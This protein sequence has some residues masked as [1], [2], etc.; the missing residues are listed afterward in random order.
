VRQNKKKA[1]MRASPDYVRLENQEYVLYPPLF[2]LSLFISIF[3]FREV[4]I[5]KPMLNVCRWLD[6]TDRENPEF[7]YTL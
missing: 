4:G 1:Q 3:V 7:V 5:K 2:L 6:L